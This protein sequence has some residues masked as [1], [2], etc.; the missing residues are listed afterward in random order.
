[1]RLGHYIS[2]IKNSHS[3]PVLEIGQAHEDM[4]IVD[5]HKKTANRDGTKNAIEA[6]AN[7]IAAMML[8]PKELVEKLIKANYT[9][10]QMAAK[11]QVSIAAM[12]IR[13]N[14]L[15]YQTLETW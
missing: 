3:K 7:A 6:E 1:M 15:D 14:K 10:E 13:L 9:L 11:F 12:A 8:M 2:Y 4:E 5:N